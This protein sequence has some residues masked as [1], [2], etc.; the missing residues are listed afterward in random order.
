RFLAVGERPLASFK[1]AVFWP[2][3]PTGQ[4]RL[5]GA[6]GGLGGLYKPPKGPQYVL[7]SSFELSSPPLNILAILSLSLSGAILHYLGGDLIFHTLG[8]LMATEGGAAPAPHSSSNPPS[9]DPAWAHGIVVDMA[10]RKVQC[11]Y[12]NRSDSHSHDSYE[13]YGSYQVPK[14]PGYIPI[15][16]IYANTDAYSQY[17][18]QYEA[19]YQHYMGVIHPPLAWPDPVGLG[20][21]RPSRA[22]DRQVKNANLNNKNVKLHK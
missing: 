20:P 11:K 6:F 13:S 4:K 21:A 19:Y 15:T 14:I 12:C 16:I 9:A 17:L 2:L 3:P 18:T 7:N 5:L 22:R 8:I 1:L 10:R